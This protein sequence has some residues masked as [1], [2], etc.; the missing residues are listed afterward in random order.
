M[1][2]DAVADS[3]PERTAALV[4]ALGQPRLLAMLRRY[5][6]DLAG[7]SAAAVAGAD[8]RSLHA[9]AHRLLGSGS[10]LGLDAT[11]AALATVCDAIAAHPDGA[12][13]AM[14]QNALALAEAACDRGWRALAPVLPDAAG[15]DAAASKR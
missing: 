7:L 4:A 15:H 13:R 3:H 14:V 6:D 11:A 8:D 1:Q 10:T 5:R 2:P 12:P 9:W